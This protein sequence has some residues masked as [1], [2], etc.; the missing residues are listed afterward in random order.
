MFYNKDMIRLSNTLITI[1]CDQRLAFDM[2][3]QEK[4]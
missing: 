2:L 1:L 3:K 4:I